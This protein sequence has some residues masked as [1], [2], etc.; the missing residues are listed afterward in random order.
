LRQEQNGTNPRKEGHVTKGIEKVNAEVDVSVFSM[1]H[2]RE[3]L[4]GDDI[5]LVRSGRKRKKQ[6]TKQQQKKKHQR[7]SISFLMEH[8]LCMGLKLK[9]SSSR[10][11]EGACN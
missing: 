4:Q 11:R 1:A 2:P 10:E 9:M 6:K 5:F 7:S 3:S 8:L